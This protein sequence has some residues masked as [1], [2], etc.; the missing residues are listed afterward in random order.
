ML[1][2]SIIN[3]VRYGLEDVL[4][5]VVR[6]SVVFYGLL[7][8]VYRDRA[9]M[10]AD[11]RTRATTLT[12]EEYGE[13][14]RKFP[15]LLDTTDLNQTCIYRITSSVVGESV[16]DV[17]CG[18][19]WF[20]NHLEQNTQ[21]NV[22]GVDFIVPDEMKQKYP[23]VTFVEGA[24]EKLPFA[25]KAFDT[26]VCTHTLEHIVQ[27]DRALA[28]LRRISRKR[29]MVVVPCEREYK[30]AFNLH[31][32]FFPYKHSFLNRLA[33]LPAS[34]SCEVLDGEDRKSVV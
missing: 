9:R 20:V 12:A 19:G 4:P 31:V 10:I 30:Y 27:F 5:A 16:I 28:E 7:K 15:A 2:R 22:T 6:D 13:Y 18:R 3:K 25:D 21:K 8:L 17:G 33:P 14:Y 1:N 29:L 23:R 11:F 26:V 34:Y 32:N 24:I